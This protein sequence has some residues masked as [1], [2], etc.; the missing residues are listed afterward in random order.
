MNQH[1]YIR[2]LLSFLPPGEARGG[3]GGVVGTK[4]LIWDWKQQ[5]ATH[6]AAGSKEAIFL[7]KERKKLQNPTLDAKNLTYYVFTNRE[8]NTFWDHE[9][10]MTK[11]LIG[12]II[13]IR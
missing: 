1:N 5:E 6:M 2:S 13:K 11:Q 8:A 10:S 3:R 7:R 4:S 9:C 12:R